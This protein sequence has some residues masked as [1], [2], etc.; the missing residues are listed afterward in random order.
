LWE[1]RGAANKALFNL[2][3]WTNNFLCI[4]VKLCQNIV[5]IILCDWNIVK[6]KQKILG[7]SVWGTPVWETIP[8]MKERPPA[9]PI[10]HCRWT[11]QRLVGVAGVDDLSS[12]YCYFG[13]DLILLDNY[14][15]RPRIHKKWQLILRRILS[16]HIHYSI[17]QIPAWSIFTSVSIS[18]KFL[19]VLP[20]PQKKL[21]IL[22]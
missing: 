16:N 12:L 18:G 5:W 13:L 6:G 21:W 2:N 22:I 20:Y 11:C 9:P 17:R 19:K 8:Q 1:R 14:L 3:Y 15:W 10:E 7:A 4:C